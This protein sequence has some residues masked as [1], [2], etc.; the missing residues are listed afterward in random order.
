MRNQ[1]GDSDCCS[2]KQEEIWTNEKKESSAYMQPQVKDDMAYF[3]NM[4]QRKYKRKWPL[5]FHF[6]EQ[7]FHTNS[8][9]QV[10]TLQE[11]NQPKFFIFTPQNTAL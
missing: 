11:E 1:R 10:A 9:P 4:T 6:V 3:D 7:N 5:I 2:Q 8:L